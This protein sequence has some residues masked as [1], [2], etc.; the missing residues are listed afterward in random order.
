MSATIVIRPAQHS[1]TQCYFSSSNFY[2]YCH[3]TTSTTRTTAATTADKTAVPPGEG[4]ESVGSIKWA[5]A[6]AQ[7]IAFVSVWSVAEG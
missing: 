1:A 4:K 6:A 3:T 5:P 2:F 7:P